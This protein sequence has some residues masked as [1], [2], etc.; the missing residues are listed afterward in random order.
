MTESN[1]GHLR[2]GGLDL[3]VTG[4]AEAAG[5]GLTQIHLAGGRRRG[6]IGGLLGEFLTWTDTGPARSDPS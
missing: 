6:A 4:P 1:A 5:E 3:M 2:L